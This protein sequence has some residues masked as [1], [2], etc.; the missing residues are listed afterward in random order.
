MIRK[1]S[2]NFFIIQGW[3]NVKQ[4]FIQKNQ[5]CLNWVIFSKLMPYDKNGNSSFSLD[6][7][8]LGRKISLKSKKYSRLDLERISAGNVFLWGEIQCTILHIRFFLHF[9]PSK[10][11]LCHKKD[12]NQSKQK[13]VPNI[14]E[15][16][17]IHEFWTWIKYIR[18]VIWR[19]FRWKFLKSN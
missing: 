6:V 3:Q 16:F 11:N 14:R 7:L 5:K 1:Y 10:K 8:F 12:V 9:L 19:I 4:K 15:E 13:R 2:S 17:W 18:T